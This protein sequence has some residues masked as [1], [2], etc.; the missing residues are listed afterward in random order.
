MLHGPS[1]AA[2]ALL[3]CFDLRMALGLCALAV[4]TTHASAASATVLCD[5]TGSYAVNGVSATAHVAS[6]VTASIGFGVKRTRGWYA[7]SIAVAA[8][9]LAHSVTVFAIDAADGRS[10]GDNELDPI[11]V[12]TMVIETSGMV[13]A[14]S[15]LT[16]VLALGPDEERA[17]VAPY[18]APVPSGAVLGLRLAF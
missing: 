2:T 10:C 1:S 14:T 18:A 16:A 8:L 13:A 9:N 11:G 17:L 6:V 5:N 15:L 7:A 3:L 4:L 12:P